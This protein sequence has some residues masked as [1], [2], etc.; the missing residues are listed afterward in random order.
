MKLFSSTLTSFPDI[1]IGSFFDGKITSATS[2]ITRLQL[3]ATL[4]YNSVCSFLRF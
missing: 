1:I 2:L 4:E 3:E